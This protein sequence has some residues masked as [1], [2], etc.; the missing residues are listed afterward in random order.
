MRATLKT[1]TV[2][3][4]VF[5]TL[6]VPVGLYALHYLE[7]AAALL[8]SGLRANFLDHPIAFLTH[9]TAGGLALLAA[10][11]Q[12]LPSLRQRWPRLHRWTGRVYVAA[13]LVSGLAGLRI[14][15]GTAYGPAAIAGFASLSIVWIA[16][17]TC[18]FL[19]IRAGDID[20]H[21][22]WML[23]SVALTFAAVTIR[24]QLIAIVAFQLDFAVAY[25]A[26]SWLCWLPNL[27]LAE[28]WIRRRVSPRR[29]AV[30]GQS[31]TRRPPAE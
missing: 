26:A 6:A 11:W 16:T 14:A 10:P 22:A 8:P 15:F 12:L 9:T 29:A 20:R 25:A 1:Q 3:W 23:R 7:G 4:L 5:A 30:A 27:V 2:S 13:C 17:T 19:A 21:R 18:G 24:L 31:E 28:W